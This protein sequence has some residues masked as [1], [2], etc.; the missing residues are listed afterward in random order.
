MPYQ[1][2]ACTAAQVEERLDATELETTELEDRMDELEIAIDEEE[3]EL[4][5]RVALETVDDWAL[6]DVAVPQMDPVT[7]G[8]SIAPPLAFTCKP[9]DTFCPGGILAFQLRLVAE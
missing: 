4:D 8:V 9:K 3:R 5:N 2:Q 6:E 7:A 1:L